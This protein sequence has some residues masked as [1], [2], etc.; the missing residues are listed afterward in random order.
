L[1]KGILANPCQGHNLFQFV[2]LCIGQLHHQCIN[3][4]P[5]INLFVKDA[6]AIRMV[7]GSSRSF[8]RLKVPCKALWQALK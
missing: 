4:G 8:T 7:N 3:R 2:P 6:D 5:F 1:G